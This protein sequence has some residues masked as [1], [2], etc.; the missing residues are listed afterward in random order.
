MTQTVLF[1]TL[2]TERLRLRMLTRDDADALFRHFADDTVRRYMGMAAFTRRQDAEEM[3]DFFN[4]VTARG[5][6]TRWAIIRKE[7]GA[8]LGTCGFYFWDKERQRCEIGYDL[9]P[10]VWGEGTMHEALTAMIG[11]LFDELDLHR[12]EALTDPVNSRSQNVLLRLGFRM[13]GVLRDHDKVGGE[14]LDDC[15]FALLRPDWRAAQRGDAPAAHRAGRLISHRTV[16]ALQV[17]GVRYRG[18]A[19][20]VRDERSRTSPRRCPLTASS[21]SMCATWIRLKRR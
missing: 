16:D 6:A 8:F 5:E 21:W 1:P 15:M 12:L 20:A 3:I 13:E 11:Y 10:A 17:V 2:E 19:P 4:T 9:A 18:D 7:D 14:F